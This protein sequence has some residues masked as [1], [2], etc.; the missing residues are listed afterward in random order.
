CEFWSSYFF[1]QAEDG[2]RDFHVTGVQTCALPIYTHYRTGFDYFQT[3]LQKFFL[4]ERVPYLHCRKFFH[5]FLGNIGRSERSTTN[6]VFTCSRSDDEYRV[7]YPFCS[8]RNSFPCFDNT[9]T[10]GIHQRVGMI[11]F[12]KIYFTAHCRYSETVSIM[13]ATVN[14]T[15]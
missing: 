7:S 14:Y 4:L 3:S 13:T 6:T 2:I 8:S 1:F 12:F 10:H 5:A 15:G 9:R 11:T